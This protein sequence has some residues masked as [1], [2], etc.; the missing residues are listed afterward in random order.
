[1][2]FGEFVEAIVER[3]VEIGKLPILVVA[4]QQE[5]P[6]LL[7]FGSVHGRTL[8]SRGDRATGSPGAK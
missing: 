2:L 6:D 3:V 4:R 1:V 8:L 7:R 5:M